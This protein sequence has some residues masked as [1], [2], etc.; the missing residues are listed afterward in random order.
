MYTHRY[1]YH[2]HGHSSYHHQNHLHH[3][4]SLVIMIALYCHL[5]HIALITV[6]VYAITVL[7]LNNLA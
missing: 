6:M 4:I 1:E 3:I 2:H 7:A 5:H